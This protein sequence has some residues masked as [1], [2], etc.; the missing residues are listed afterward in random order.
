MWRAALQGYIDIDERLSVD[1]EVVRNGWVENEVVLKE[2]WTTGCRVQWDV[3]APPK[4]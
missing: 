1:E 3:A 2:A 4:S